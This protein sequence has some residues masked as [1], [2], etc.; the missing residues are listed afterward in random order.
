M[1]ESWL[2]YG[3]TEV[4]IRIPDENL[5]GIVEANDLKGVDNPHKEVVDAIERPLDSPK[6]SDIV[7]SGSRIAIVVD[8]KTRPLPTRLLL[9]CILKS[10]DQ[11][12]VKDYEVTVI[13]KSRYYLSREARCGFLYLNVDAD[14]FTYDII[15]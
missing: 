15:C 6:L 5:L 7:R 2:P 4:A 3:R 12:G 10:L 13:F 14:R 11:S 8:D 1:I 9:S